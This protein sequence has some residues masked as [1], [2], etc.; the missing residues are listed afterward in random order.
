MK[1]AKQW[2]DEMKLRPCVTE[3]DLL[4]IIKAIQTDALKS[5]PIPEWLS[6]ALNEGD[7]TYK[8]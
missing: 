3:S 8:P 6:Q 4:V 7:G 5:P 2:F 1:T